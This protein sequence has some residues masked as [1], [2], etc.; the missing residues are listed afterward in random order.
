M[1]SIFSAI[2]RTLMANR[3]GSLD[4]R[5]SAGAAWGKE[6]KIEWLGLACSFDLY[7]SELGPADEGLTPLYDVSEN[8]LSRLGGSTYLA[9]G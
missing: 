7:S 6:A 4:Y 1:P 2:A 3:V 9:Q 5:A 8:A